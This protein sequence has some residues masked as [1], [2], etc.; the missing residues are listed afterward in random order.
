[1]VSYQRRKEEIRRHADRMALER[2]QWIHK[3]IYYYENDYTYM[4]FSVPPG[5]KILEV[6]CG[7][8]NLLAQLN[9]RVGVGIDISTKMIEIAQKKFPDYHFECGDA[10]NP[11]FMAQLPGPF[12]VIIMSDTIGALSDCQTALQNLHPL[13][14]PDTRLVISYYSRLWE[15]ILKLAEVAGAK[16]TQPEQNW[17]STDDICNLL[18]ISQFEIIKSE[19]RQ[20]LPKRLGGAGTFVNRYLAPW[21]II[22]RFCLRSYVIARI[23]PHLSR[24]PRPK[25]A[26]VLIP[27]RNERGNIVSAIERIPAFCE[28]IEILFVEGGSSDETLTEIKAAIASY[29]DK[30]IRVLEQEGKGKGDAVR[31]GFSE[32]RGEV[33]M[34]LDADLTMPPEDLP[35][36]FEVLASGQG[37]F[38]NGSRLVYPMENDAMRFL[39]Y[40]ANA[41]FSWLFTWILSQRFTDT[42]CGTKVLYRRDYRLIS[43]N[44]SYFGDYD[45]FGDFDLI[46]GAVKLNKKVVEIP[47]R[48]AERVYG[49][50]QISRFRHG[51]LLLKMVI[52]AFKKFKAF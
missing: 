17:L 48:Y 16:M 46:F 22:N 25:S 40:L 26:T 31:K 5:L 28:Q 29:P 18:R 11:D 36:Y 9:P 50:T 38:I 49:S 10:E 19:W 2:D 4:R 42:L 33:L 41:M 8:G 30:S 32:A 43:D 13:C 20:L 15:P 6:G 44:R 51:W 27:C 47:I 39:N 24:H 35:K 45:P 37:E 1:M 21:P 52:R 14:T 34:I 12:D 3:N 23:S 7:T